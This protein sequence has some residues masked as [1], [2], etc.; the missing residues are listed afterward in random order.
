MLLRAHDHRLSLHDFRMVPGR[1]HMNLV[2]D[3]ELPWDL[4]GREEAI[5]LEIEEFLN[6]ETNRAYHVRITFDTAQTM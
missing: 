4:R 2:F 3:V 5:R 1:T 6:R